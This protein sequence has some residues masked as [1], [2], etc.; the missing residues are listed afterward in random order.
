MSQISTLLLKNK[1]V[2]LSKNKE[3]RYAH[4]FMSSKLLSNSETS[5]RKPAKEATRF[6]RV[7]CLMLCK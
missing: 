4:L 6:S 3:K 1:A 5:I 7:K 2:Q